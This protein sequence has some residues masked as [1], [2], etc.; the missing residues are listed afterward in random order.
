[1]AAPTPRRRSARLIVIGSVAALAATFAAAGIA[2]LARRH[3]QPS[4]LVVS[5][6]T[7]PGAGVQ[8]SIT[9][10]APV[11]L[12][13]VTFRGT[14]IALDAGEKEG[15]AFRR[16]PIFPISVT[17]SWDGP[18]LQF[19][20]GPDPGSGAALS[21]EGCK[22]LVKD[23]AVTFLPSDRTTRT[24][25]IELVSSGPVHDLDGRLSYV[26][27]PGAVPPV[28]DLRVDMTRLEPG[29]RHSYDL[30]ELSNLALA[31]VSVDATWAGDVPLSLI[32]RH[33]GDSDARRSSTSPLEVTAS[34][35]PGDEL[36]DATMENSA[37]GPAVNVALAL[38]FPLGASS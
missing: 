37:A 20:F 23:S 22:P 2:I 15:V 29:E 7:R 6:P 4:V 14:G 31:P 36:W 21:D 35:P 11:A 27:A 3:T 8:S 16:D 17:A 5:P 24:Y 30:G 33:D 34:R 28:A 26:A 18:A 12:G 19:C 32:L 1:M 13:A 38:R 10:T 25:F 9:T